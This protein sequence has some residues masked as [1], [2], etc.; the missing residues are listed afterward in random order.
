MLN[1]G[2]VDGRATGSGRTF[3]VSDPATLEVVAEV[4]STTPGE[5]EEAILAARRAFDTGPWPRMSAAERQAVLREFADHL[6]KR[7]AEL[8]EVVIAETGCPRVVTE[9]GQVGL[10]LAQARDFP[11]LFA[12]LPEWEHNELPLA[13]HLQPGGTSVRLSIRRYEPVGVVAA[14]AASN[15]PLVTSVVKVLPALSTGCTVVLRPNPLA[16]LAVLALGEAAEAAG[17]PAGVLNV[18]V[19]EGNAGAVAMTSHPAVDMVTFTGSTAVGTAVAGQAAPTLKR[20]VLELGGKSAQLYLPDALAE[21]PGRA[22]RGALT[23]LGTHAGQACVAQSRMLVPRAS[24]DSV[25]DALGAATAHLAIG[26]PRDPATRVGPLI[27]EAQRDRCARLV[28]ASVAAGGRVVA[29]GGVPAAPGRGWYF[30]P[31]VIAVE[32]NADPAAQ[33]EVFGPVLTVQAYDS[34]DEAVAIANDTDYGLSG[35]V[36]TDDLAAG[37]AVA[38]R[39]RAGNVHVNTGCATAHTPSGGMRRSGLGRERGVL[40]LR[41][42][43][44]V[45][46]VAVGSA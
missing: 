32:S 13:E 7:R 42:F 25:L 19:E 44:E 6:E 18:V 17:L 43:Q 28:A 39:I 20:L 45:K 22:V 15:F 37:L 30:E 14:I 41:S 12:S 29:G 27:S 1:T 46:H 3:E 36:Y 10:P 4:R 31:T 40:G 38:E 2:Y 23:M 5:V 24:Y 21:G 34:L 9:Y 33:Q 26:D 16:P 35:A 8:V 11:A